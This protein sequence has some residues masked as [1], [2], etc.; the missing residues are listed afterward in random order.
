MPARPTGEDKA[1]CRAAG[2]TTKNVAE[3]NPLTVAVQACADKASEKYQ[4]QHDD[5][6][7]K[8]NSDHDYVLVA[9][10]TRARVTSS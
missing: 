3:A 4:A 1:G 8:C 6:H 10:P 5:Y 9:N 2:S 7:N